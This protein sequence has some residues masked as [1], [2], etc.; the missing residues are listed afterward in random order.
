MHAQLIEG[1]TTPQRRGEMDKIVTDEMLPPCT[2]SPVS[3][4][5]S[6]SSTAG[7]ATRSW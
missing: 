4:A 3:P 5:L 6:T 2:P 7:A 1:G